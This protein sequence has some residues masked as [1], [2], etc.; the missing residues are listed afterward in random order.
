MPF[1]KS[2]KQKFNEMLLYKTFFNQLIQ[3]KNSEY[4][5]LITHLYQV[6]QKSFRQ[7]SLPNKLY[8]IIEKK[9][10]KFNIELINHLSILSII[11]IIMKLLFY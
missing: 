3:A 11:I 4:Y 6:G 5:H 2:F 9:D 7:I 10:M 1:F 8:F